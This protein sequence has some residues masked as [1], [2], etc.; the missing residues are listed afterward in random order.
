MLML[1]GAFLG[2]HLTDQA[3]FQSHCWV[4]RVLGRQQSKMLIAVYFRMHPFLSVVW[5]PAWVRCSPQ[6][7]ALAFCTKGE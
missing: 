3:A 6:L 4:S 7:S 1:C 2:L 5:W